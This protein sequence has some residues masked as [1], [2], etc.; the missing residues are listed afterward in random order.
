[1][2]LTPWVN[3]IEL[4]SEDALQSEDGE[5]HHKDSFGKQ[6]NEKGATETPE[7]VMREVEVANVC[8]F[9]DLGPLGRAHL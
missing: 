3:E 1:V 5:Y 9:R 6:S 8:V 4:V 2:D 7:S